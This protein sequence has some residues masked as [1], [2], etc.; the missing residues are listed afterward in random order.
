ML[1]DNNLGIFHGFHYPS[2]WRF[3][4]S[5]INPIKISKGVSFEAILSHVT[6]EDG[7]DLI[8]FIRESWANSDE[9][10]NLSAAIE[11][12]N[13]RQ[14]QKFRKVI[15]SKRFLFIDYAK[16]FIFKDKLFLIFT[17]TSI[18]PF[19]GLR[20][21][22]KGVVEQISFEEIWYRVEIEKILPKLRIR[23]LFIDIGVSKDIHFSELKRINKA[24]SDISYNPI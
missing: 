5:V 4:K 23:V 18:W 13:L 24:W 9:I 17:S 20:G 2:D 16:V 19:E 7:E 14:Y 21:F 22:H 10:L 3:K 12:A 11:E 8:A 15:Q 6:T 1:F